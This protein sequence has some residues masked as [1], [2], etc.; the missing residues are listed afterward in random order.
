MKKLFLIAFLLISGLGYSQGNGGQSDENNVLF[1]K[2]V[3]YFVGPNSN[4]H[5]FAVENKLNCD[6]EVRFEVGQNQ[7][8]KDTTFKANETIFFNVPGSSIEL[9]SGK[10]KRTGKANCVLNPDNGWVEIQSNGVIL[11]IT[12]LSFKFIKKTKIN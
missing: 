9:L 6:V 1:I 5:R 12:V 2:Y 4:Y 10:A 3:A 8:T 11:P 7:F